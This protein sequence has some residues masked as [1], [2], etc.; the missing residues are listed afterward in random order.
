MLYRLAD[1]DFSQKNFPTLA[2]SLSLNPPIIKPVAF[3]ILNTIYFSTHIV[4]ETFKNLRLQN[5][6]K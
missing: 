4:E 3:L 2:C 6:T 5:E 1:P